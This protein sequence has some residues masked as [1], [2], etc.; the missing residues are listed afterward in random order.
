[1]YNNFFPLKEL[2]NDK[3]IKPKK[4]WVTWD[5]LKLI[6]KKNRLY[7][8]YLKNPSESRKNKYKKCRNDVN[9][10][11]RRS[12]R[13]YYYDKFESVKNNLKKTWSI[14]NDILGKKENYTK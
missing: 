10:M 14:I 13:K 7:K 3:N 5:I 1:M 4:P 6:K 12:K 9:T 8:L 11:L 2:H